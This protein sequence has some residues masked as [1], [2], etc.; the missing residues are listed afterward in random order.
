MIFPFLPP[1]TANQDRPTQQASGGRNGRLFFLPHVE[2]TPAAAVFFF[3]LAVRSAGKGSLP[4]F[5][6]LRIGSSLQTHRFRDQ[7]GM[8]RK[9]FPLDAEGRQ[10]RADLHAGNRQSP[11]QPAGVFGQ[12]VLRGKVEISLRLGFAFLFFGVRL[13]LGA[14]L[15]KILADFLGILVEILHLFVVFLQLAGLAGQSGQQAF[16]GAVE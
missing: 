14:A 3:G 16:G 2:Q 11:N 13:L 4:F 7:G 15:L 12:Q 9:I 6:S 10:F 1:G 5:D 8:G